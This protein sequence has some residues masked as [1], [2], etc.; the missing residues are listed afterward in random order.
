MRWL[1]A[2]CFVLTAFILVGCAPQG[3]TE[4]SSKEPSANGAER[5][6]PITNEEPIQS[7]GVNM[8]AKVLFIIAQTNFRDEEL[9]KP[10]A[11]LEKAGYKCDVAS[12]STTFATGMLGAVVK[13]DL[14]VRE[15]DAE[16]YE[17]L[18]VIGGSGAPELAK[19]NEVI[20]L[21]TAA[22][23][24]GKKLA[25][26]CL[27]PMVLAKAGVLSGKQ[28]TVFKTKESL[29]ALQQGG[30]EYVEQSVVTDFN[31]VTANGPEAAEAFG[32]ALVKL[33]QGSK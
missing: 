32:N 14:A 27:G 7:G 22:D 11:I 3:V 8:S 12:L 16:D 18:V 17:L 1:V 25:A 21:L 31:L 13:P 9:A 28:A 26:I 23:D 30:A 2:V 20:N 15:V 33:L 24:S 5:A 6:E 4:G 29:A 19:H 10:K